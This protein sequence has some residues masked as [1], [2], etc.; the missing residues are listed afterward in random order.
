MFTW[1]I[2]LTKAEA[3]CGLDPAECGSG[4]RAWKTSKF[5]SLSLFLHTVSNHLLHGIQCLCSE[6]W[7]LHES[8][9]MGTLLWLLLNDLSNRQEHFGK[10]HDSVSISAHDFVEHTLNMMIQHNPIQTRVFDPKGNETLLFAR[11]AENLKLALNYHTL[12]SRWTWS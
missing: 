11:Q 1:C 9:M 12:S 6:A 4:R 5:V 7:F 8:K 2:C 10:F 3:R